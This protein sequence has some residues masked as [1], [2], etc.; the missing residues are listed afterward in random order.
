MVKLICLLTGESFIDLFM[1]YKYFVFVF[2]L[3]GFFGSQLYSKLL[4]TKARNRKIEIQQM[5]LE[6]LWITMGFSVV[7]FFILM[8]V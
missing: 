8:L 6:Y 3:V 7:L 5:Q 1:M 4:I 2:I